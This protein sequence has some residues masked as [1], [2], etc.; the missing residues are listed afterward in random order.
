[1]HLLRKLGYRGGQG[2][3]RSFDELV[4]GSGY[5]TDEDIEAATGAGYLIAGGT[6]SPD[7]IRHA[8]YELRLGEA[9]VAPLA[10]PKGQDFDFTIR[11][12]SSEAPLRMQ[13][14]EIALLYSIEVVS[15]PSNVL[16]FTVARGL[17]FAE[18]LGP[19]NTYV[20][21]GFTKTLYTTVVNRSNR[22]ITLTYGMPIARLFFYK[23]G[24]PVKTPYGPGQSR[25]IGQQVASE[26][27]SDVA[28]PDEA[29]AKTANELV[30]AVRVVPMAGNQ[31]VELVLR[32]RSARAAELRRTRIWF[33]ALAVYV[34]VLPV[35]SSALEAFPKF[36]SFLE[37]FGETIAAHLVSLVV[38]TVVPVIAWVSRL[39]GIPARHHE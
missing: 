25:Q 17:L 21:P 14:G 39:L 22:I 26:I 24:R 36:R 33:A 29:K 11:R 31:I 15:L 7:R 35:V 16:G 6:S 27:S 30:E 28:T 4:T 20:D 3:S 2:L 19:E 37:L 13:P 5:L 1:M 38:V 34:I 10:P 8:S 32:E 18:G 23:L 12:L 9:H